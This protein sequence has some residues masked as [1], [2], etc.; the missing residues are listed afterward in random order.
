LGITPIDQLTIH[1]NKT[2]AICER[3]RPFPLVN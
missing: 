1:P 2:I 3:H